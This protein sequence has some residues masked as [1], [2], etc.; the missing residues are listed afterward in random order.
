MSIKERRALVVDDEPMTRMLH[1]YLL[2]NFGY[3]VETA[4]NGVDALEFIKK[5]QFDFVLLDAQ[6]PKLNGF[7]VAIAVRNM[8][9]VEELPLIGI[10]A[11]CDK[12]IFEQAKKAGINEVLIKPIAEEDVKKIIT[13]YAENEAGKATAKKIKNNKESK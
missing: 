4:S 2:L 13:D 11:Q 12:T 10:T 7:E 5:E 6:M 8:G 1:K 3:S 9:K